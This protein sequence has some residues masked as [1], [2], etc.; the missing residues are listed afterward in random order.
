MK[1]IN[2]YLTVVTPLISRKKLS[3]VNLTL[4]TTFLGGGAGQKL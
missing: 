4:G 1:I 3:L 2:T